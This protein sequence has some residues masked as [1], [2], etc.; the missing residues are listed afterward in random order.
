M[1]CCGLSCFWSPV[2]LTFCAAGWLQGG[3]FTPALL[4]DAEPQ[5]VIIVAVH[6]GNSPREIRDDMELPSGNWRIFKIAMEN[7][8]FIDDLWRFT[9]KKWWFSM[10]ML[11]NQRVYSWFAVVLLV[12][13]LNGLKQLK[14]NM[15]F[16]DSFWTISCNWI[17]IYIHTEICLGLKSTMRWR[18]PGS[19]RDRAGVPRPSAGK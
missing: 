12:D 8:P 1:G 6:G 4:D 18:C 5:K 11:N 7:G 17:Y 9:F 10:A 3:S 14:D 19:V 13:M 2:T 16:I 15:F